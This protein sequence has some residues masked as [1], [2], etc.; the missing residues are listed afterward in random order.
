MNLRIRRMTKLLGVITG[1]IF[2]AFHCEAYAADGGQSKDSRVVAYV[3]SGTTTLP[4]ADD[5]TNI[6]Y[7]FGVVNDT[8]DGITINNPERLRRI[9]GLKDKN[10]DLEVM[11]SIGGWGAGGF[12]EM[13][14]N[15]KLR[16]KF[17]ADCKRIIKEYSLD[18]IDLDWEYPTS[19]K[20][21]I[22]ASPKDARNYTK[23]I[24]DLRKALPRPLLL[25]MASPCHAAYYDFPSIVKYIDFVNVMTYDMGT[26]PRHHSA[27]HPSQH[28]KYSAEQA[29]EAHLKAGVPASKLVLGIPFYGIGKSPYGN[30]VSYR[31]IRQKQGCSERWDSIACVPYMADSIG[32]LVLTYDNP[33]SISIKCDFIKEHGLLGA[34]YWNYAGDNTR[35][36]L[37]KAVAEGILRRETQP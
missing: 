22:V 33:R 1:L 14:A 3:T 8:F 28:T 36:D 31:D 16:K 18:G 9:V 2:L 34:M 17:V 25:T 27:L 35:G 30:Y 24:K 32:N 7:A 11:L 23:L 20:A 29:L 15:G 10:P 5:M 12:S 13:A 26:P 6:N 19:D 4:S 37:R 21:G